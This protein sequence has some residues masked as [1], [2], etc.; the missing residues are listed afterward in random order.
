[1]VWMYAPF[2]VGA[3]LIVIGLSIA[4]YMFDGNTKSTK[5]Y[6]RQPAH[7]PVRWHLSISDQLRKRRSMRSIHSIDI[8]STS[9]GNIRGS[10]EDIKLHVQ[11]YTY[12]N[13][14]KV[15]KN[16]KAIRVIGKTNTKRF[17]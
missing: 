3:F 11:E 15:T 5:K 13:M 12:Q 10:A 1:M 16:M 8:D 4:L 6:R 9:L 17:R 7:L 2:V 14:N